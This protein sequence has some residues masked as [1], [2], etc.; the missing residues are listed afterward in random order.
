M[1]NSVREAHILG[2]N[3]PLKK[4]FKHALGSRSASDSIFLKLCLEDGTLGYGESLP[5]EYVTGETPQSVAGALRDILRSKV[6]GFAPAGYSEVP[7]FINGLAIE[8]QAARCAL[9]LA[10]L[11][12]YGRYFNMGLSSV[13][14][15]RIK[16][17]VIYSGVIEAGSMQ[18][19][20]KLSLLFRIFGLHFIK[21]KVGVGD[22][23]ARL[24]TVRFIS[25]EDANI[26]VD[27]NCAWEPDEAI[28]KIDRMREY[29]ISAVE[30]PTAQDDYNGLKRVTDSV[31]ETIIADES[32]CSVDDAERLAKLRAC[33][34]FSIRIS[35]CGGILN[36]LKIADIARHNNIDIQLGCQVGES[37]LLSAVGRHF[38]SLVWDISFYEGS[39]GKFLLK[40]DV[41]KEDMTMRRGGIGG[42]VEG[43]GLGVGVLDEVLKRY[44]VS[45]DVVR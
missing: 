1:G 17:P 36:S 25:G 13:V 18:D 45:E 11:D 3:L 44:T 37:G 28:E 34:M 40:E 5:R 7:P 39:Y 9:E 27:A 2:V 30:Q 32:L 16:A 6:L 35:K 23:I 38:A 24:K 15:G 12:A 42:P 21:V 33:N 19:T 43:P 14:G 41:T 29:A 31:P 8:G 20:I 22:D 4:S 10:L 26:R